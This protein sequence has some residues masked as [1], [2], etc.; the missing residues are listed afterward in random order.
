MAGSPGALWGALLLP[1]RPS[2][3]SLAFRGRPAL[4]PAAVQTLSE[5]L[6]AFFKNKIHTHLVGMNSWKFLV[7]VGGWVLGRWAG[8]IC[9]G[10]RLGIRTFGRVKLARISSLGIY[11]RQKSA[12]DHNLST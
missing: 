6:S 10:S 8:P 4:R 5:K 7:V 12:P 11:L 2:G 3:A 1:G 9:P